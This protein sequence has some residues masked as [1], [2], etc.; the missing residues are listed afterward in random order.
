MKKNN[1]SSSRRKLIKMAIGAGAAGL[2]M[3]NRLR[4]RLTD[5]KITLIGARTHHYYQPGY[6]MIASGLWKKESVISQ[7]SDWLPQGVDWIAQN[8]KSVSGAT[9][10]VILADG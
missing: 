6:T 8:V 5:N 2:A 9:K 4:H 7:M 3:V 10:T 1:Y